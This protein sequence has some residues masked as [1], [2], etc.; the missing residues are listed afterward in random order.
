MVIR[1]IENL[2]I[3]YYFFYFLIDWIFFLIFLW[4]VKREKCNLAHHDDFEHYP[5]SILVPAYNEEVT[6]I[7]SV[8][9]L[10][11]LDY[12]DFEV[13]VVN[14]GSKDGTL[15]KIL[16]SFPVLKVVPS[17]NID[18]NKTYIS[19]QKVN[20]VY[21]GLNGRLLVI[22]K[23]NGGKADAI[24]VGI[25][26]SQKK[27]VCTIDAD[28]V[29]DKQAL[30]QTVQ[31]MLDDEKVFVS[32]GQ[33]AVANGVS[34]VDNKVVNSVLPDNRWVQW[35]I[36]EYLK[37]F[38][39]ARYS[40]S[41][42]N[43]ILI[44]SGAFSVYKKKDLLQVGGFLTKNNDSDYLKNIKTTG[45]QTVCEDMEIVVRLWRYFYD[46]GEKARAVFL[47]HPVCWTEV[48]DNP[49]FLLRQ[50]NRWH[51]G[52]AETLKIHGS[53]LGDPKY[54]AIGLFA[55]PYYMFF[56][57]LAP[58]I[59]IITFAFLIVAGSLGY[60]NESWVLLALLFAT[61]ASAVITCLSTIFIE[62]WT[63][64]K[65]LASYDALR[66][67]TGWDWLKLIMMS[68]WGDFVYAPFRIYAQLL[69]LKDFLQKK[70]EW[71]KF[72]RTGFGNQEEK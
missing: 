39:I 14:D 57:L 16:A 9:M 40:M 72:S 28:S 18:D 56:E 65:Q 24:N 50:R 5:V 52:L 36:I 61:F 33:L 31:P 49:G 22:D 6:I 13:I 20:A 67:K 26:Y 27:L 64:K 29:L 4:Q 48:P 2:L 8:Q 71:Y 15:A 3:L 59:K 30:K 17:K 1:V 58:I 34:L 66:Y 69:G 25:N 47:P 70:N 54:K 51:R 38:M 32:G 11:A 21:T 35:Q 7:P 19:T 45:K 55:F 10:L 42:M 23:A 12:P 44:M 43:A 37:S 62:Q 68:I 53:M 60:F 46:K 63:R 41:K